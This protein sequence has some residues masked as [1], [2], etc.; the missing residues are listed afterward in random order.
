MSPEHAL[1]A[2]GVLA[3]NCT[4]FDDVSVAAYAA[5]FRRLDYPD[6]LADAVDATVQTW[7][8]YTRP[9]VGTVLAE[10]RRLLARL[11]QDVAAD[12]LET[13]TGTAA[14]GTTAA[15]LATATNLMADADWLHARGTPDHDHDAGR[16]ACPRCSDVALDQ[17]WADAQA[18]A[19]DRV[20]AGR[21]RPLAEAG[22]GSKAPA[23]R[24][25]L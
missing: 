6:V 17:R 10:Y 5:Q 2:A 21:A 13:T 7:T 9:P 16:Q 23:G 24:P 25:R 18:E 1:T 14:T 12:V 19:A 3:A 4:G 15:V 11:R 22:I 20:A 8:A